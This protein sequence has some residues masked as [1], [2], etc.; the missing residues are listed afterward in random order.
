MRTFSYKV[1]EDKSEGLST[2]SAI[3]YVDGDDKSKDIYMGV[4][5]HLSIANFLVFSLKD[6]A[7]QF[8]SI[9]LDDPAILNPPQAEVEDDGNMC[10]LQSMFNNV[11]TLTDAKDLLH[12]AMHTQ[13][14]LVLEISEG[15]GVPVSEVMDSIRSR[16]GYVNFDPAIG[17]KG[18]NEVGH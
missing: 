6:A 1:V 2:Y 8:G 18:N 9:N 15:K 5:P 3:A 16:D 10:P 7:R 17:G 13:V 11:T 14:D 4:F 12:G